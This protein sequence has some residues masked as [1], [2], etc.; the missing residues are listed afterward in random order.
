MSLTSFLVS[1]NWASERLRTAL[2]LLGIAFGTA[3]VVA[4]YVMDHN[5]IQS[6][7]RQQDPQRGPVDVEVTALKARPTADVRKELG[8][9]AGVSAVAIWRQGHGVA[10]RGP[11]MAALEVYGLD[12]L[13][14]ACSPTT[15]SSRARN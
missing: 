7:M 10:V 2:T 5:T 13:P 3:V 1:R 9:H 4:I 11:G 8:S 15:R 12:P 6:R 14:A